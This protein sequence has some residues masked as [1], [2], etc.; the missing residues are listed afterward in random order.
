MKVSAMDY[1][2]YDSVVAKLLREGLTNSQIVAKILKTK[3]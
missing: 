3:E 2:Q 1:Y